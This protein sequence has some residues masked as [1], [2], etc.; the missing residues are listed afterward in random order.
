MEI[1]VR[2]NKLSL[3]TPG[4]VTLPLL[5]MIQKG[6]SVPTMVPH[7]RHI[8]PTT[9]ESMHALAAP[10]VFRGH[11]IKVQ[12]CVFLLMGGGGSGSP[13]ISPQSFRDG[14]CGGVYGGISFK[15]MDKCWCFLRLVP[16]HELL[17][18]HVILSFGQTLL[19]VPLTYRADANCVDHVW[20]KSYKFYKKVGSR[21]F[22][23]C[24]RAPMHMY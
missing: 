11:C 23:S 1:P 24:I 5:T 17:C 13:T 6:W 15:H 16:H 14:H 20:Y 3:W 10:Q 19:Y 18:A 2:C 7:K 21:Q 8:A 9:W 22:Q 4:G 12:V